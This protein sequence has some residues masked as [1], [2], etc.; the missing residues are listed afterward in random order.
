MLNMKEIKYNKLIVTLL[1]IVLLLGGC[2]K[3]T[4]PVDTG[5]GILGAN[6][7]FAIKPEP[8]TEFFLNLYH[9]QEEDEPFYQRDPDV[10]LRRTLTTSDIEDGFTLPIE[11]LDRSGYAYVTAFVDLDGD[12]Q[13]SEGDIATCYFEHTLRDVMRGRAT[14]SNVAHREFLTIEMSEVYTTLVPFKAE[15]QFPIPPATETVLTFNLYYADV[16]EPRFFDREP[17][18]VITKT[19]T[20]QEIAN[21]LTISLD[22]M[23]D[24]AYVYATA[25]LDI[26]GNGVLNHGDIAMGYNDIP[27]KDI[28]DGKV[29]ADNMSEEDETVWSMGEW[30]IDENGTVV[31]IDGNVYT[32]VIIGNKEWMVENLKVTRYRTGASITTNLSNAVWEAT[33]NDG[34][35]G[36]Y[37]VFPYTETGGAVQSEAEM[38]AK[39]GLLYNGFA[40]GDTRGLAPVGWRVPTDD[41][42]KDLELAIGLPETLLDETSWRGTNTASPNVS[43]KLRST[44]DWP[45]VGTDDFGFKALPAGVRGSDGAYANFFNA[46]T[47]ARAVFWTSTDGTTNTVGYRRMLESNRSHTILRST[48]TKREG[49]SVRCVRDVPDNDGD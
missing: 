31:D 22:D 26:N 8:G 12:E 40:V 11:Q 38:I 46:G 33:Y 16:A 25:Y 18:A 4:N 28:L 39:Y 10:V 1:G 7:S 41:D 29:E 44:A 35:V 42:Y 43:L 3:E 34:R 20:E 6:V 45:V 37:A 17:D 2:K 5:S 47:T 19:L 30:F 23:E 13:I 32:T 27:L 21:G 36:A 9:T 24:R 14:P 49:Y 48:I 15:F